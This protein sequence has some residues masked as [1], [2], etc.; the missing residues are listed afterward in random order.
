[1]KGVLVVPNVTMHGWNCYAREG[2]RHNSLPHGLLSVATEANRN[3]HHVTIVDLRRHKCIED[4]V[5][6]TLL[7]DPEFVGV[8]AMTVDFPVAC[9]YLKRLKE[10][11]RHVTTVMGGVHVSIKPEDAEKKAQIDYILTGEGEW[12][13]CDMLRD[14]FVGYERVVAGEPP[15]LDALLPIDRE[16]IDYRGGELYHGGQW[17]SAYPFVTVMVGRGCP[18]K[19][20]FCYPVSDTVFGPK[21]RI[22]S[23]AH[24]M[25]ELKH[26]TRQYHPA[27]IEF[28]D[29]LFTLRRKWVE[30]FIREYP[31]VCGGIPFNVAC[32]ADI[33]VK[34]P[35]MFEALRGIG[36][37]TVNVG[38]ESGCQRHLDY[39]EKGTTVEQ[40]YEACRTLKR[41]GC[42]IVGNIIHGIPGE[43]PSETMQ[44]V[45]LVK[46]CDVDYY[47]PAFLTPYPGCKLHETLGK[48]LVPSDYAQMNRHAKDAKIEG[49][50]YD[51]IMTILKAE[52][53]KAFK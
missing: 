10:K 2:R 15:D 51:A 9:D 21:V 33:I 20:A 29:D 7:R 27:Y 11:A 32:R 42:R 28:I 34:R 45:R 25:M 14:Y 47:S 39:L 23:V 40:N 26:L 37:D 36:L 17:H 19:C 5:N 50:E 24:V 38:L 49:V 6:D 41:L 53:P 3:G 31:K 44:T 46:D 16:L 43:T 22:R 35:A 52:F 13:L 30:E 1:M 4:A 48:D 8:G 18:H 12:T